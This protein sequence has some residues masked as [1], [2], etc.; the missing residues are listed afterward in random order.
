M[1]RTILI[2]VLALLV[3]ATVLV[4][5]DGTKAALRVAQGSVS[6]AKAINFKSPAIYPF[7]IAA[8][9]LNNDGFPDL[10]VMG[11]NPENLLHALGTGDGHVGHW[12]H[13]GRVEGGGNVLFADVDLDG[14]LDAVTM[15]ADVV[16]AFGQG[17]GHFKGSVVLRN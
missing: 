4:A 14:N 6:F 10:G 2:I 12:S 15:S 8:G 3:G 16:V 9:D 1:K 13:D 11:Q 17:N 7:S 5:R